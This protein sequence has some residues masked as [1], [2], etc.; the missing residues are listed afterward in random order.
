M[1]VGIWYFLSKTRTGLSLRAV[2]ENTATADAAGI[3]VTKYKYLATCIGAGISGLGGTY[4]VMPMTTEMM[5]W[6]TFITMPSTVSGM[7]EPYCV[8]A[9]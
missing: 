6:K 7:S 8:P 1:A 2:G 4:Y 5:I 9:P 3:S